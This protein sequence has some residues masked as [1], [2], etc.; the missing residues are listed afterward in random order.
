MSRLLPLRSTRVYA[1]PEELTSQIAI[2]VL[3]DPICIVNR[4]GRIVQTNAA[5]DSLLYAHPMDYIRSH[6]TEDSKVPVDEA[7]SALL[8]D[9]ALYQKVDLAFIT[10]SIRSGANIGTYDWQLRRNEKS[11]MVMLLGR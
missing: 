8:K 1:E 4:L 10:S 6:L 7:L 3:P 5:F 2:D 11:N 9:G